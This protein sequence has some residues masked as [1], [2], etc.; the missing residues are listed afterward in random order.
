MKRK[1]LAIFAGVVVLQV[2]G[3]YT[4]EQY[5]TPATAASAFSERASATG[6]PAQPP[7]VTPEDATLSDIDANGNTIAYYDHHEQVVVKNRQD[8]VVALVP[9]Q[10]VQFLQWL[11]NGVTLFYVRDNYGQNEM[12][13]LKVQENQVVPLYDIPGADVKID[14]VFKSS[15]SQ[16]I[17]LLYFNGEQLYIGSYEQITGWQSEPLYGIKPQKSWF[18]EK[19]DVMYV[20]DTDGAVWRFQNGNLTHSK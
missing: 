12:G 7:L 5:L 4:L 8:E 15:Y 1:R 3:L 17:H 20:Q 19:E 2:V 6:Q 18:D 14:N 13:V 10:G 9:L 16:S 11:D